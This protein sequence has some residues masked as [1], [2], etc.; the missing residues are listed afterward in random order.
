MLFLIYLDLST[1]IR[2]IYT[3]GHKHDADIYTTG[4]LLYEN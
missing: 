2:Y 3:G 1:I 4:R